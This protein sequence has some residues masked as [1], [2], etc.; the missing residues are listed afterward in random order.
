MNDRTPELPFGAHDSRKR[1]VPKERLAGSEPF[2]LEP[3]SL[4]DFFGSE[5]GDAEDARGTDDL[6]AKGSIKSDGFV[7]EIERL[8]RLS[9]PTPTP[10][11]VQTSSNDERQSSVFGSKTERSSAFQSSPR[12]DGVDPFHASFK[13]QAPLPSQLASSLRS[14]TAEA[15]ERLAEKS[16]IRTNHKPTLPSERRAAR[17]T[18]RPETASTAPRAATSAR[19]FPKSDAAAPEQP[20]QPRFHPM[21]GEPLTSADAISDPPLFENF[22]KSEN[23]APRIGCVSSVVI[24][25]I[26]LI[27]GSEFDMGLP[28]LIVGLIVIAAINSARSQ[29]PS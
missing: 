20:A 9:A 12:A 23:Q 7:S 10:S 13:S 29:K 17:T 24:L 11:V 26:F 19:S 2:D 18:S 14:S 3:T 22:K 4:D 8:T 27:V 16:E 25:M 28:A 5:T 21:T 1:R 6:A 15:L